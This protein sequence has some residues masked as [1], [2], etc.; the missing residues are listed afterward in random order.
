LCEHAIAA[1]DQRRIA[2]H[3]AE[4]ALPEGK[5]IATFDFAAVA[6][7]RKAQIMA[8]AESDAWID[9]APIC[10]A[11]VQAASARATPPPPSVMR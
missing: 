8:L 11:S 3:L 4:S 10:S 2:R 5:T 9:L 1:R 7:A 6:S